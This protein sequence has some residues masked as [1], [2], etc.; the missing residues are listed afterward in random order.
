MDGTG[1]IKRR[2]SDELKQQI[3]AYNEI[4]PLVE[5]EKKP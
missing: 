2:I 3:L 1:Y 4:V 5:L